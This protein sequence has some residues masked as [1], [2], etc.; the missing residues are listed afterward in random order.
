[1]PRAPPVTKWRKDEESDMKERRVFSLKQ[2]EFDTD[3]YL[4][5]FKHMITRIN[6]RYHFSL[7]NNVFSLFF[8]SNSKV[9]ESKEKIEKFRL[10]EEAATNLGSAVYLK[11]NEIDDLISSNRIV[12]SAVHPDSG[13]IIPFYARMSGFVIFNVPLVFAVMFTRNQTP[14]MNA[15]F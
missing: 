13:K 12:G 3:S 10:R 9:E 14:L 5:R 4:G 6:P 1:M 11:Q 8:I 15:G 2:S 7:S